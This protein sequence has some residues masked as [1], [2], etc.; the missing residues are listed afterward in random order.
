MYS[1]ISKLVVAFMFQPLFN[2]NPPFFLAFKTTWQI[3]N[4]CLHGGKW[5][6]VHFKGNHVSIIEQISV[7]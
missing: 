1:F 2:L 4:A 6:S 5:K 3:F 7:A